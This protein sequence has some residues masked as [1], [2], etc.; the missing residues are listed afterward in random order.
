MRAVKVNTGAEPP[1]FRVVGVSLRLG[2]KLIV[3]VLLAVVVACPILLLARATVPITV[4][5]NPPSPSANTGF[6]ISGQFVGY[7][8]GVDWTLFL[9]AA[10]SS[11]VPR[12]EGPAFTG[13]T[14]GDGAYSAY[15][16]GH[17]AG[18]Y[19]VTVMDDFGD[20]SGRVCFTILPSTTTT[21]ASNSV[22]AG[23]ANLAHKNY[24]AISPISC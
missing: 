18:T 9:D 10:D 24:C 7:G 8:S 17:P 12:N 6:T 22:Y 20:N 14:G 1:R 21:T 15:I 4:T 16:W 23:D 3:M 19:V 13:T 5:I 11:C 2:H